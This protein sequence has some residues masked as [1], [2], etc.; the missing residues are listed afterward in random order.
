VDLEQVPAVPVPSS[1]RPPLVAR[2]EIELFL[3]AAGHLVP[4]MRLRWQVQ[5]D[6]LSETAGAQ[7]YVTH[8]RDPAYPA[9]EELAS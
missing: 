9:A 4:R 7:G 8:R 1:L 6:S 2:W 3:D 5:D